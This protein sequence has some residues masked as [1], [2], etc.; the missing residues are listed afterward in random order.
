MLVRYAFSRY[1]GYM[2]NSGERLEIIREV[3][4]TALDSSFEEVQNKVDQKFEGAKEIQGNNTNPTG[5]QTLQDGVQNLL[6]TL[7]LTLA[8]NLGL[9][10]DELEKVFDEVI[11]LLGSYKNKKGE[12]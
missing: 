8:K 7:L 6:I 11:K 12:S 5:G 4:T 9:K 1:N 3:V 2:E 10:E